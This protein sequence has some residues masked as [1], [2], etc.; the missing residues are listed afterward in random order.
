MPQVPQK[1]LRLV[2]E[3]FEG[4]IIKAQLWFEIDNPVLNGMKP[5]NYHQGGKWDRLEKMIHDALK[6]NKDD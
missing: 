1:L 6:E 3:H 4:N 5:R 2:T